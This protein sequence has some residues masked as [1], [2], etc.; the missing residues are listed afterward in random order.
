MQIEIIKT[1]TPKE[2]PDENKLGFGKYFTDHMFIMD[3]SP[4]KGWH[5]PKIIPFGNLTLHPASTVFHYGAEIFEGL[6][7]YRTPHRRR[8]AFPSHRKYHPSE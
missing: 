6:K 2:K 7:A 5:D 3:Y 1:Q 4:D 8:S